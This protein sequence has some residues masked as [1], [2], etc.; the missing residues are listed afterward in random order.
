MLKS[1]KNIWFWPNVPGACDGTRTC[2]LRITNALHYQLCYTSI[3]N[4]RKYTIFNAFCQEFI[5]QTFI[6]WKENYLFMKKLA[7]IDLGSNSIRMSIFE[8]NPDKTYRQTGNYRSMIKLSEGMTED[9][10]LQPKAQLRAVNALLEYKQIMQNEGVTALR[11]VAT[12]AVRKAENG[13]DFVAAVKNAVGITIEVIDG[14]TEA[15]LDCLAISGTLGCKD[16]VI[17]D[18]GGGSTEFIAICDGEM[19]KPAVS[20]PIGSRWITETFFAKGE[21]PQ[22]ISDAE[23]YIGEHISELPWLEQMKGAPIVGI[24]GTLRALA[25]YH[26]GDFSKSAIAH[27]EI[28]ANEIDRLF[29]VIASA[30]FEERKSMP[31]IG[32]ERAD[33]ISGGLVPLMELK[34]AITAPS[35]VVADVGVREGILF[36]YMNK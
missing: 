15:A 25:K 1:K 9:M 8:I 33:I 6:I 22:A 32:E 34:K 31:G 18:I 16:G 12:A 4:I 5:I 26:M 14:E 2:D 24:G 27:H 23:K 17:C 7:V 13:D 29:E 19:Q 3:F 10:R 20:I 28:P 11:A 36:D 21:S 30:S 35:L